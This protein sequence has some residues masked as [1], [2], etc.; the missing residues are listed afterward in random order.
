MDALSLVHQLNQRYRAEFD[1]AEQLQ[2]QLQAIQG[3]RLWPW[4]ARVQKLAGWCRSRLSSSRIKPERTPSHDLN[5]GNWSTPFIPQSVHKLTANDV[6]IVIPFRD[7]L[8]LLE[9]CV[10]PL[11]RT[12]PEA[13]LVLVDNGSAEAST[14]S[15]LH[16]CRINKQATVVHLD[17]P[18][19]FSRL[20]NVGAAVVHREMLLFLN[21]DVLATQPGWIE[22]MLEL[23]GD[24][25]V[26]I[27][28]ATLLYPDRTLQHVGLA[29]LGPA[30]T[31]IHPY[32]GEPETY[33]G[34]QHE[35]RHVRSVPAVTGACLLIR[36]ALFESLGGF[37]PRY[38]TI[39]ND[40]DLCLRAKAQGWEI[41][42]TPFARLWHFE[43][44]SRGYTREAA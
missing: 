42:V 2:D 3:S 21:N 7:Q 38:S 43:S 33:L 39:F 24:P 20:C 8:D 41:V 4:F 1:R 30:Q 9:R 32:R 6:S 5:D 29:P 36:R 37:D 23:A 18:F 34:K 10:L 16:R 13:E 12:V 35:L 28:G 17:E 11:H 44:L 31:W 14:K 26:G 40:V 27:V 19:N 15:F 25:R 22:P